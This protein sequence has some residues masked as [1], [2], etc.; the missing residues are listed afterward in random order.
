MIQPGTYQTLIS[1]RTTPQGLYLDAGHLG[2]ILMPKRYIPEGH[3][4][5]DEV[6]VFIYFDSED[7]LVATTE[8][9]K[10]VLGDIV[11]LQVVSLA[12][13]YLKISNPKRGFCSS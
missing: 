8:T 3:N 6:H 13:Q 1:T 5:G 9:P 11:A 12:A 10:G 7:R 2:E 4:I